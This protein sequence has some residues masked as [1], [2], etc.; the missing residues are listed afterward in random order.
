MDTSLLKQVWPAGK[1]G[2]AE[3]FPSEGVPARDAREKRGGVRT[4]VDAFE[5][6]RRRHERVI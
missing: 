4:G 3:R 5:S 1:T 2:H 6:R